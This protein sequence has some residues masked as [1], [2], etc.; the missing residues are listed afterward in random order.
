[1]TW[2]SIIGA[3]LNFAIELWSNRANPELAKARAAASIT[4]DM[5][6]D[7]ASFDKA[8]ADNDTQAMSAHFEQLRDRVAK[9]TGG[10]NLE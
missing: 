2:L 5:N 4:K 7:L 8:L 6:R 1:M 10:K 9:L 3:L